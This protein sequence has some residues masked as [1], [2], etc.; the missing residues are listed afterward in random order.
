M[1]IVLSSSE[2]AFSGSEKSDK[3]RRE[4]WMKPSKDFLSSDDFEQKNAKIKPAAES[5]I[6]FSIQFLSFLR[7]T[8]FCANI[9]SFF[10]CQ[11]VAFLLKWNGH[12]SRSSCSVDT[13]S[14][15]RKE[16]QSWFTTVPKN[17]KSWAH[18]INKK[19]KLDSPHFLSSINHDHKAFACRE[20]I[21][22][23]LLTLRSS[24]FPC[25]WTMKEDSGLLDLY[26]SKGRA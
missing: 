15:R 16:S 2:S 12:H 24:S 26:L 9:S 6:F 18:I 20:S 13:C 8:P 3:H 10:Q 19:P 23:S 22:L 25:K 5:N 1:E 21:E 14:V 11:S 7:N 17:G 4:S